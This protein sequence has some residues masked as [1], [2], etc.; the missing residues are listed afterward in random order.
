MMRLVF[1]RAVLGMALIGGFV[2]LGCSSDKPSA[3]LER[4][5]GTDTIAVLTNADEVETF[6][7]DSKSFYPDKR[8]LKGE[9]IDG[10][11]VIRKG[12]S[13]G[14]DFAE[15]MRALLFRGSSYK[16]GRAICFEPGVAYRF[17]QGEMSVDVLIC[18]MCDNVDI[19][20]NTKDNYGTEI[21]LADLTR[22][23]RAVLLALTKEAFSD[24][25]E[26]QAIAEK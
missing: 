26:I 9:R 6:R 13:Q 12:K 10:F 15:R 18:F 20:P 16:E 17:K 24:D 5:L 23:A 7:I 22:K 19:Q 4:M 21:Q 3:D 1:F 14:P 25:V 11:L 8:D 2:I